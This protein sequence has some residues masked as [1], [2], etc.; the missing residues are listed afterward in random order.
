MKVRD[1]R[2]C[3]PTLGK[4]PLPGGDL[5]LGVS[6]VQRREQSVRRSDAILERRMQRDLNCHRVVAPV[7][8]LQR[9]CEVGRPDIEAAK[10]RISV[11]RRTRLA[12]RPCKEPDPASPYARGLRRDS[13]RPAPN[14]HAGYEQQ[15]HRHRLSHREVLADSRSR[16][17]ARSSRAC[18][19]PGSHQREESIAS[20]PSCEMAATACEA[21]GRPHGCPSSPASP[22]RPVE[23]SGASPRPV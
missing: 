3:G 6:I 22:A 9:R 4:E 15:P 20:L 13:G 17:S 23:C 12:K 10:E 11:R 1:R 21:E 5:S 18:G 8:R 19:G 2:A 7:K 16:T 14:R